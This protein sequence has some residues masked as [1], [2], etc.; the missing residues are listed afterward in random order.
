MKEQQNIRIH[1]DFSDGTELSFYE[2]I[3]AYRNGEKFNTHCLSFFDFLF[4]CVLIKKNG[5]TLTPNKLIE[6]RGFY[7][8]KEIKHTHNIYRMLVAGAFKGWDCFD[9][10]GD[11]DKIDKERI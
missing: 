9:V 6:D 2:S 7:T 10:I 4:D 1:W 11:E 5:E 3:Q 8:S